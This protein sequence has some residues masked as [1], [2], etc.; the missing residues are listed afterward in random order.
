MQMLSRGEFETL[1][2]V[3][4]GPAVSVYLATHAAGAQTRHDRIRLDGLLDEAA[5]AVAALGV[6]GAA[7]AA[8][9]EPARM[10]T[11]EPRFWAARAQGLALFL[12]PRVLRHYRVPIGLAEL[13]VVSD[14]FHLKPLFRLFT[15]DGRFYLLALGESGLRLYQ[16]SHEQLA[17]LDVATLPR[18]LAEA[19][20]AEEPPAPPQLHAGAPRSPAGSI[21]HG[22][23]HGHGA[24]GDEAILRHF[25]RVDQ[26]LGAIL[27]RETAPLVLAGVEHLLPIYRAA[28]R[29]PHLL[30]AGVPGRPERLALAALHERAWRVVAP[31]FAAAESAARRRFHAL[32]GSERGPGRLA[33][34]ALAAAEGRVETLFV[35]VGVQR[36]GRVDPAARRV[37]ERAEPAPGDYDLLD[38]AAQETFLHGGVV[39]AVPPDRVPGDGEVAAALRH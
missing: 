27:E 38:F 24:G 9:F 36:W 12:T 10:L 26:A 14:R 30:E 34:I 3:R 28:N 31:V 39:Y 33:D 5:G 2:G 23:G 7:A 4:E 21:F 16:G 15:G 20:A 11:G 1:L 13:A 19:L 29:Y 22:H 25:R 32:R 6:R 35:P 18:E 37:D 17:P 8:M